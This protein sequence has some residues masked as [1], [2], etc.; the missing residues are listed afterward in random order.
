MG[1]LEA[2]RKVFAANPVN[3][4]PGEV[5]AGMS[6]ATA[7]GPGTALQPYDGYSR[8]PRAHDYQT[9]Y[10]I[11]ARPRR[12][13]RVS[14]DTLRALID[15]YDVAQICIWHRI[16]SVRSLEWNL[17]GKPGTSGTDLDDAIATGVAALEFPDRELP[18]TAW[19]AKYLYDV[20]AYDAGVLYRMRNEA[21]RPIGLKVVD[22][23]TIAPLLD[24]WGD[25]PQAPTEAYVQFI[26]GI[27]FNWLTEDD[28]VYVPFRPISNSPYGRAP[29]ES[30]LLNANTDLRF[31]AY[32]MGRFTQGTVP[33]GFAESPADWTPAQIEAFQE[34]W[35]AMMYGDESK[36][37][38]IKWVPNGTKLMWS[39]EKTFEDTFSLFLM[40]KTAAAF[41]I[42]PAD[43]GFTEDVNKSSG[44]TQADVQ[45]RIGDLPLIQHTEGII[46]RFLQFD[47]GL[48]LQFKF[49]TGQETEDQLIAAQ[50]HD[51]YIKAGVVSVSEVREQAYGLSEPDGIAVARFIYTARAGPIPLDALR[52]VAGPLDPETGSPLPSAPLPHKPFTPVEG[53][54]PNPAPVAPAL[55]VQKFPADNPAAAD[56]AASAVISEATPTPITSVPVSAT[57]V[58]KTLA[59]AVAAVDA[60]V[61]AETVG[62]TADTGAVGNPLLGRDDDEAA[63][64]HNP[65]G[66]LRDPNDPVHPVGPVDLVDGTGLVTKELR[67]FDKYVEARRKEGRWRRPFKFAAVAPV[68]A[69]R[70]ND[71]GRTLVRKDAGQLVA[72]GLCVQ[73]DDTGRV[74]MLQRAFDP[75]D[76]ASGMWEF[77]GGHIEDGESAF[78]AA[79]REWQEETGCLLPA[80][81]VADA[82]ATS[83]T[84]AASNGVYCGYVLRLPSEGDIPILQRGACTN[85]DDPDGDYVEAI[86][87]WPPNLL[88][89]NPALR[90]E[91]AAD[92]PL[93]MGALAP[94]LQ[95]VKADVVPPKAPAQPTPSR[96]TPTTGG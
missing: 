3:P 27:P 28:L 69:H 56:A 79:V 47:L 19:L 18:F 40:R 96:G 81:A 60:V 4:T 52:A 33:Q 54:A 31:Q 49:D 86:A 1:V 35:D 43:L 23:T 89:G 2:V 38:Q 75:D 8:N 11:A 65:D 34:A 5:A 15:A 64:G 91:L 90:S 21:G 88:D 66:S 78:S 42:T 58:A 32:F 53:V 94:K 67:A 22:G 37:H 59:E 84:W 70:L 14:F 72:A 13:E 44:D 80:V 10:N 71:A 17:V 63:V 24:E 12:N 92:L 29:I 50:A 73:A 62:I 51:I 9:G 55:A 46:S 93:V 6:T 83:A 20:L 26:Q 68:M 41:H 30:I 76:P 7:F 74:L 16:D 85:P 95:V 82:Y 25:R 48:P 36:K 57:G 45:F 87:W 61:K 39:D 77:P